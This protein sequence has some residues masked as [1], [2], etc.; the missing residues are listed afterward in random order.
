MACFQSLG[1]IPVSSD[2]WNMI[3][4]IGAWSSLSSRCEISSGPWA[5]LGFKP[6][7]NVSTPWTVILIGGM[8]GWLSFDIELFSSCMRLSGE[9]FEKMDSNCLLNMLACDTG[10]KWVRPNEKSQLSSAI[11]MFFGLLVFKKNAK[12]FLLTTAWCVRKDDWFY[13]WQVCISQLFLYGWLKRFEL[14]SVVT[15]MWTVPFQFCVQFVSFSY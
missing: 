5:L 4:R 13:V 1:T 6:V 7:N 14:F 15:F 8:G 2:L 9:G 3:A 12:R 11:S 10:S